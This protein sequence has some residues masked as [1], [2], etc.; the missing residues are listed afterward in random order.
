MKKP[1]YPRS[2]KAL[3]MKPFLAMDVLERAQELERQGRTIVHLEV[4]EPDFPTPEPVKMAAIQAL[5]QDKT[6]Y[7]HSM[8]LLELRQAVADHYHRRYRVDISPEQVLITSGTSPALLL[9]CATLLNPG[10]RILLTDP[11][12]ACYA[13]FIS[14]CDGIPDLVQVYEDNG[15]QY[16]PEALQNRINPATRGILINS[17]ANPTGTLL[18]A[19]RMRQ[20]AELGI[21]VISD[22]IYHGLVYEGQAHSILEYTDRAFVLNGFSKLYA[23]TGWR[24]GYLIAPKAYIRTM[25][26]IQQNFFI[27]ASHFGQEATIVALESAEVEQEVEKMKE[28]YN[29]RRQY[30]LKRVRGMGLTIKT[31]PTGAFYVFANAKEFCDNSYEFA[32]EILEKAG[33]G[34]TPGIDFGSNGEGFIRFTYANSMENIREGMDRL[35]EFLRHRRSGEK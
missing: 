7:T 20:I 29:Q 17:P 33:V 32:F 24:L 23:M 34:V 31:E 14:F 27:A 3:G 16:N 5:N 25:Q 21:P 19:E 28:I 12:Y 30:M 18:A 10:D 1:S 4:G 13:N 26:T 35:E 2:K 15:F 8:G 22:E 6:H 11:G 9:V